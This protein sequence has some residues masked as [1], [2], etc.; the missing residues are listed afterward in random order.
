MSSSPP[1]DT[2]TQELLLKRAHRRALHYGIV[3]TWFERV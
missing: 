2:E 1:M 3:L